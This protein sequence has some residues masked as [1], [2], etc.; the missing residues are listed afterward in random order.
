M[1]HA[2]GGVGCETEAGHC[3]SIWGV[4]TPALTILQIETLLPT[5]YTLHIQTRGRVPPHTALDMALSWQ[6]EDSVSN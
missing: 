1:L 5:L 3:H 6:S 4:G 2:D